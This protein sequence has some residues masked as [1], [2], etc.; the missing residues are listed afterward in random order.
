MSL[1]MCVTGQKCRGHQRDLV[2]CGIDHTSP[3]GDVS[4]CDMSL[5]FVIYNFFFLPIFNFWIS[6]GVLP[7]F[8]SCNTWYTSYTSTTTTLPIHLSIDLLKQLSIIPQL[9]QSK[10]LK[11][12]PLQETIKTINYHKY[13]QLYVNNVTNHQEN[14]KNI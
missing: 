3:I 9:S 10:H 6:R 14:I 13:I 5:N 1:V 12:Y 2:T 8:W 4:K 11:N 7:K